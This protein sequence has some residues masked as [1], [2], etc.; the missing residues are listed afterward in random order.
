METVSGIGTTLYGKK[1]LDKESGWYTTTKWFVI[2][3]LPIIP[4][5]SYRVKRGETYTGMPEGQVLLGTSTEF[6]MKK[7]KLDWLQVVKTFLIGW[8][9]GI[10]LMYLLYWIAGTY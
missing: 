7:I 4:L 5:G 3:F 2:V 6:E 9:I 10:G 1:D 8:G